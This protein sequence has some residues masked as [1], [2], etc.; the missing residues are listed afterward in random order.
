MD[1][2][3]ES[4]RLPTESGRVD[5]QAALVADFM[6]CSLTTRGS[7][8]SCLYMSVTLVFLTST[9]VHL[10]STIFQSKAT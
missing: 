4:G 7:S 5:V 6:I 1:D 3:S 9:P 8:T 2:L 10:D